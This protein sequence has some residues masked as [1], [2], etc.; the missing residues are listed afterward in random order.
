MIDKNDYTF[1]FD[2]CEAPKSKFFAQPYSVVVNICSTIMVLYFLCKTRT[3]HAFL[4]LLSLLAFDLSHTFSHFTHIKSKLQITLVHV[5]AYLLNFAFFYALYKHTNKAPTL[6]FLL[7]LLGILS[8]DVY[9][10]FNLSLLFYIFTQILFFFSV[11]IY[12]YGALSSNMK[13][14]LNVLLLFIGL[15]YLGFVN[16]A[17]NCKKMLKYYPNFP[18]HAIIEVLILFAVYFFC[19]TFYTI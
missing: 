9:A 8:F 18:F 1:P 5:L 14:K 3:T 19:Q 10:F 11:F 2:T 12:Y 13:Q 15:V 7:L 4:L 17:I 6:P 16:E